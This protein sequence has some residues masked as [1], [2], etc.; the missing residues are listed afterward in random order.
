MRHDLDA[1]LDQCLTWLRTGMDIESCL[2]RYPEYAAEL[3]PLL[4][5]AVDLARVRVPASAV[6]VRAAGQRRMVAILAQKQQRLARVHPAARFARQMLWSLVPGRPGSL[7][8][9]WQ[10]AAVMLTIL[11]LASGW[12][13]V[14]ASADSLPGDVLYP[15]KLA[16]QR[17]QLAL[18][19]DPAKHRMMAD[20]L[21][22]QRRLDVQA[23]LKG[24]RQ[25]AV[26]FRGVLQQIEENLWVVSDLPVGLQETTIVGQPSLGTVVHVRAVLPGNGELVAKW[27]KVV[28]TPTPD[29]TETGQPTTTPAPSRTPRP[30]ETQKPT[31]ALESTVTM[32]TTGI[33]TRSDTPDPS[34]TPEQSGMPDPDKTR[35]HRTPDPTETPEA[36]ETR[37]SD[38]TP[39]PTET[40]EPDETHEREGTPG[41]TKTPEP[42]ETREHEETPDPTETPEPDDAHEHEGTPDPTE[43]PEPDDKAEEDHT[44]DPTG[45]ADD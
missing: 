43:T 35:E 13:T 7:R 27:L 38:G 40:P 36:D 3:R 41:P 28:S 8:S 15:V 45:E 4:E 37:E 32:R 10:L 6:G 34:E 21:E 17:A 11:F 14:A 30:V 9:A 29:P 25:V 1:A 39:D 5:L 33:P 12:M 19:L 26:E 23:V 24:R 42:D 2:G 18:T 31:R 22:T 44:P 16:S 20:H